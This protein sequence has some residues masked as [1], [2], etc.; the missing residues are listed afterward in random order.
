MGIT[1]AQMSPP[2]LIGHFN[3]R[4]NLPASTQFDIVIWHSMAVKMTFTFDEDTGRSREP[5]R[6]AMAKPK[7]EVVLSVDPNDNF[8]KTIVLAHFF[9]RMTSNTAFSKGSRLA[10]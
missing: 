2:R 6:R 4:T 8:L 5:D 1:T 7:S 9:A 3:P 10:K